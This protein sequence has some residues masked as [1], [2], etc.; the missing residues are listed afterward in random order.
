MKKEV[1]TE[2]KNWQVG[3]EL[4]EEKRTIWWESSYNTEKE[5]QEVVDE[6]KLFQ[7]LDHSDP[8]KSNKYFYREYPE[9]EK[10]LWQVG[11]QS[12]RENITVWR[13]TGFKRNI[14]EELIKEGNCFEKN[15]FPYGDQ[16]VWLIRK[17]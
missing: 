2:E 10:K 14:A 15:N 9:D 17:K 7:T 3:V 4:W 13:E 5:A 1:K 8:N 16:T 6:L 12:R 11:T